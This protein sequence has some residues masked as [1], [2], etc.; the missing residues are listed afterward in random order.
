MTAS[1]AGLS[2]DQRGIALIAFAFFIN[3]LGTTLPTPLYPLYQQ[4]YGFSAATI[5]VIFATYALAVVAGLLVF[6]HQSDAL[7]R[8][9]VL[10]PGLALSALSAVA[11]LFAD[12]LAVL[13]V[14]RVLSGVSAGIFSGTG[15]AALVD[16]VPPE[17]RRDAAL[18]AVV[19]NIGGLSAGTLLGGLLGQYV[20]QPLRVPY[21]VDLVLALAAVVAVFLAPETVRVTTR[22][23]RLSVQRL[24]LP[25]EMRT[26]F[27]R[28]AI[29]GMAA[30]AVSGVFSSV[31][32]VMLSRELGMPEPALSGVLVFVLFATSCAGQIVVERL[33]R[34]LAFASGAALLLAGLAALAAAIAWA[35]PTA[36]FVSA[37]L[38]GIGQGIVVGFGLANVH[39]RVAP[40]HRGAVTSTYFVLLYIALAIPVV[41]VG[42]LSKV[43]GLRTAGLAFCA[44]VAAALFA[45]LAWRE[46]ERAPTAAD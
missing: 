16:F 22:R 17:R 39:Q 34:Q 27:V 2:P 44:V 41:G 10:L 18:K 46:Q 9:A 1:R 3:M 26:T 38:A 43:L 36:L 8:R 31:A 7:G 12:H 23:F 33:P 32:P 20:A 11:F 15:T 6:G 24:R 40:E 29:A 30:F 28:A 42:L 14:G 25:P 45:T 37:L 21:A 19:A 4:Q 13:L 35:A 5:T